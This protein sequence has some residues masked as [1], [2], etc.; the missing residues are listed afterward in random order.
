M[1]V[2]VLVAIFVALTILRVNVAIT[3]A[4]VV[5]LIH[6]WYADSSFEFLLQDFWFT[7]DREV[8]LSLPMFIFAGVIMSR[9][10]IAA[11]LVRVMKAITGP[12]PGGLGIA[13]VLTMALFSAISGASVVTMMA[14]GTLMFPALISAGY[15]RSY[16]LGLMCSGGT[17]GVIIPPSIL[18]VLYGVSTEVS[19][20]D[21]FKAGWGPG[22]TMV[23][24]LCAYTLLLNSRTP[25]TPFSGKELLQ[26]L[27]DGIWSIMMPVIL[28]GGIYS[29]H[30]TVTEASA[31]SLGYAL[32]IELL[33]HRDLKP[34]YIRGIATES[35]SLIGSILPLLAVAGSLNTILDYQGV[36]QAVVAWSSQAIH[37]QWQLMLVVNS[38]LV[39]AGALMDE[40]SAIVIFAPLMA[41][42][43]AAYGYDPVHFAMIVIVNLQLGYVVPPVAINLIVATVV[44][45][46]SF[47]EVCKSVL[48][49]IVIMLVVLLITIMVPQLSLV[50]LGRG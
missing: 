16:S 13:A 18:M 19:I 49:F 29:G 46:A 30:F 34:H 33:I 32:I 9:G 12:V 37:S 14:V 7:V 5:G 50:F 27:R 1:N 38:L 8:L 36:P 28:L 4:L 43:G 15:S 23:A 10:S 39:L 20:T 45:K 11:R 41:P 40:G 22:L 42:L 35:I 26:A 25:T 21:M 47:A 31:I 6:V 3:L 24:A 17:L 48:P 44:F 2:F